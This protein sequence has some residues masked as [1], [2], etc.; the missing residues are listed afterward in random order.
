MDD[1]DITS[2]TCDNVDEKFDIDDEIGTNA[3]TLWMWLQNGYSQQS[4]LTKTRV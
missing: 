1:K 2:T 3:G 4:C